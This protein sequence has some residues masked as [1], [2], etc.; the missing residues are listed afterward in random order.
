MSLAEKLERFGRRMLS[1]VAVNLPVEVEVAALRFDALCRNLSLAG[2][3]LETEVELQLG[4]VL[5]VRIVP[6]HVP[7]VVE[8]DAEVRWRELHGAGLR[9]TTVGEREA[10]ILARIAGHE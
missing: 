9:F 2:L 5:R 7:D 3:F 6:P 1:R 10:A 4:S 8:L